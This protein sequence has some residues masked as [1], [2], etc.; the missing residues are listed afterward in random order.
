MERESW[1]VSVMTVYGLSAVVLCGRS[2][3]QNASDL[4][5]KGDLHDADHIKPSESPLNEL[6]LSFRWFLL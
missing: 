2:K 5:L 1:P 6:M 4:R 3:E